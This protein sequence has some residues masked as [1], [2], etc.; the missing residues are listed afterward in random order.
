M[1]LALWA[2]QQYTTSPV[3]KTTPT[4]DSMPPSPPKGAAGIIEAMSSASFKKR[5]EALVHDPRIKEPVEFPEGKMVS[6]IVPFSSI[7][8][9]EHS[10]ALTD[11]V[12][13]IED[14]S[15]LNFLKTSPTK[16]QVIEFI[17][18]ITTA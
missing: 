10:K 12:D 13:L 6:I 14:N 16:N 5:L 7:D 11:L 15:L 1:P 3:S 17:D 9:Y 2:T 4:K 18:N 8:Q